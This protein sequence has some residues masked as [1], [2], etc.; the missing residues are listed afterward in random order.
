MRALYR[1]LNASGVRVRRRSS[2]PII[3]TNNRQRTLKSLISEKI[4]TKEAGRL[5]HLDT[6]RHG[7]VEVTENML[8]VLVL[9][10]F[11]EE[12]QQCRRF[13]TAVSHL[14]HT[15]R[16]VSFRRW[17]TPQSQ[18][19]LR[20]HLNSDRKAVISEGL[21]AET[22]RLLGG[23]PHWHEIPR[24]LQVKWHPLHHLEGRTAI[25]TVDLALQQG[26]RAPES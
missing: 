26:S 1:S 9:G 12:R 10:G 5:V 19:R 14:E 21:E 7:D 13:F 20:L 6:R 25:N 2:P 23:L 18:R 15:G 16:H 11:S 8:A 4:L 22:A 24:A 3:C 17:L